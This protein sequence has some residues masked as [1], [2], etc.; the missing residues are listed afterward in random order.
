M[1]KYSSNLE[2]IKNEAKWGA[3]PEDKEA[4]EVAN[5]LAAS[6]ESVQI[7]TE[8]N[9]NK[10]FF[11][12]MLTNGINDDWQKIGYIKL[13]EVLKHVPLKKSAWYQGVK[14]G[15]FPKPT[16]RFGDPAYDVNDIRALL[17]VVLEKKE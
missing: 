15:K 11:E 4:V 10:N 7:T 3:D 2:K 13:N 6:V 17:G 14:D 1:T 12:S 9:E 5:P 8:D 16:Y